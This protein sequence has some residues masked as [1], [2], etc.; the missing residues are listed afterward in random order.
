MTQE[1]YDSGCSLIPC[2]DQFPIMI[3]FGKRH[4]RVNSYL[5]T[6]LML[7]GHK[8]ESPEYYPELN[9]IYEIAAKKNVSIYNYQIVMPGSSEDNY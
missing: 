8:V 7:K 3:V 6:H 2:S 4:L 9:S 1:T 5:Q